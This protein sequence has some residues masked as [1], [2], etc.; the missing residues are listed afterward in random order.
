MWGSWGSRPK[1]ISNFRRLLSRLRRRHLPLVV[2]NIQL[3]SS[4]LQRKT[5]RWVWVQWGTSSVLTNPHWGCTILQRKSHWNRSGNWTKLSH[6][7]LRKVLVLAD[8]L[9][10]QE[11]TREWTR[12]SSVL[13]ETKLYPVPYSLPIT[14][15]QIRRSAVSMRWVSYQVDC[16]SQMIKM[17]THLFYLTSSLI[18]PSMFSHPT[19]NTHRI[20]RSQILSSILRISSSRASTRSTQHSRPTRV[21]T[22][23]TSSSSKRNLIWNQT[24]TLSSPQSRARTSKRLSLE[25]TFSPITE[26]MSRI[27]RE[28]ALQVL[29]ENEASPTNRPRLW[30][31]SERSLVG[32][33]GSPLIWNKTAELVLSLWNNSNCVITSVLRT[34]GSIQITL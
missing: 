24:R 14:S 8:E 3:N 20:R 15:S 30:V 19:G 4:V 33:K 32:T 13:A 10:K 29:S 27:N 34:R 2:P 31:H 6:C 12:V 21:L 25:A 9:R 28:L 22:T 26:S 18:H 16:H 17:L 1:S 11:T 7:I 23:T 5:S